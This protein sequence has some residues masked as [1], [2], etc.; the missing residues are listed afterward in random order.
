MVALYI[1]S[2]VIVCIAVDRLRNV[3]GASKVRR[4]RSTVSKE[5]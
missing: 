2:N 3:I 4:G 1:S 5:F